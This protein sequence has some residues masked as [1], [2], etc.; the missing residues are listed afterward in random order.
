LGDI[1]ISIGSIEKDKD[2]HYETNFIEIEIP[3]SKYYEEVKEFS[4]EIMRSIFRIND[5]QNISLLE[6]YKEK[7]INKNEINGHWGIYQYSLLLK[8]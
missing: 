6:N 4:F 1:T 3:Y 2:I 8:K 7:I 5:P